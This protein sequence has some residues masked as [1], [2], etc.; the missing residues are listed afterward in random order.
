MLYGTP[1][2]SEK[3]FG[4]TLAFPCIEFCNPSDPQRKA[5]L[6]YDIVYIY[7]AD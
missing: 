3:I 4:D 2:R 7:E 6:Y 1:E 5:E